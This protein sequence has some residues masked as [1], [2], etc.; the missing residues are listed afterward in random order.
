MLDISLLE[1][2]M[3]QTPATVMAVC[4]LQA[5][6]IVTGLPWSRD[7]VSTVL[8]SSVLNVKNQELVVSSDNT[9]YLT[10]CLV[11]LHK[12]QEDEVVIIDE[13][14]SSINSSSCTV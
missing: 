2:S 1:E 5:S 10:D 11:S 6:R 8:S 7:L 3:M 13:G 14:Y 4:V 12:L 9:R